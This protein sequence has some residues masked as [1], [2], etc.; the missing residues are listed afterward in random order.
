MVAHASLNLLNAHLMVRHNPQRH[1]LGIRN[2]A[3]SI[4]EVW[5]HVAKVIEETPH[6]SLAIA[7]AR[8]VGSGVCGIKR[9]VGILACKESLLACEG[10]HV[11]CI[12]NILLVLEVELRDTALVSMSADGVVGNAHS[13]PH[14]TFVLWSL[15]YHLHNPRLVRVAYRKGLALRI[16]TILS[17]ER[18][19]HVNSLAS[20]LRA[21]KSDVDERAIIENALGVNKFLAPAERC[22]SDGHLP[23]VDVS[24]DIISLWSLGNLAMINIGVPVVNLA[25]LTLSM[26]ASRVMAKTLEHSVVIGI[27]CANDGTIGTCSF[28]HDEVCASH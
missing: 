21:L 13:H 17:N 28:C 5:H 20:C 11:F 2:L 14:S 26:L 27:I 24:N 4:V 9:E 18:C 6:T 10:Y 19:H 12:K 8:E 23:L 3:H 7:T 1:R 25:H 16:V 22:L 15:A